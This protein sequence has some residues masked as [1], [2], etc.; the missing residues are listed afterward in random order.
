MYLL[1]LT[2]IDLNKPT[3]TSLA[4]INQL[5][6]LV[7]LQ[8]DCC[9]C[10][11]ESSCIHVFIHSYIESENTYRVPTISATQCLTEH[12][13][14]KDSPYYGFS[15][16]FIFPFGNIVNTFLSPLKVS[17]GLCDWTGEWGLKW[18]KPLPGLTHWK[19]PLLSLPLW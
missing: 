12:P 2:F 15:K 8:L 10:E 4:P 17:L 5:W 9:Y 13:K 19:P 7:C 1:L 3:L 16:S 6:F 11:V 18:C 14:W